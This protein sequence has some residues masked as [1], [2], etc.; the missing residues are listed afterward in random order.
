MKGSPVFSDDDNQPYDDSAHGGQPY[1]DLEETQNELSRKIDEI[2]TKMAHS[3]KEARKV[4][5]TC[6][7]LLTAAKKELLA[8]QDQANDGM[9]S[10]S[11]ADDACAH[12]EESISSFIRSLDDYTESHNKAFH[13]MDDEKE[14]L[15][16]EKRRAWDSSPSPS[17]D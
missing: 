7:E 12:V 3:R 1:D 6:E 11:F 16:Y 15:L 5:Q 14:R 8:V 9:L 4:K 17:C 13:Q 2:D 10:F